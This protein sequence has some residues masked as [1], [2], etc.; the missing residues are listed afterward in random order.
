MCLVLKSRTL[1]A[2]FYRKKI[3]TKKVQMISLFSNRMMRP[4]PFPYHLITQ[5]S[6]FPRPVYI[7]RGIAPTG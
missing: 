3:L 1:T 6:N 5:I 4:S 2:T 7:H